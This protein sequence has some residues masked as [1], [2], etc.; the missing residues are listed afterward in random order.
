MLLNR[1]RRIGRVPDRNP[2]D[3][4]ER[5]QKSAQTDRGD[6]DGTASTEYQSIHG[7]PNQRYPDLQSCSGEDGRV[8]ADEDC[9]RRLGT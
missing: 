1:G 8:Y 6:G 2:K 3:A 9:V 7:I 4:D 5:I